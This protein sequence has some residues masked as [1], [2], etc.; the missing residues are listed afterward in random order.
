MDP[1]TIIAILGGGLLVAKGLNKPKA[2]APRQGVF[3]P[4]ALS[5]IRRPTA[6]GPGLSGPAS[7]APASAGGITSAQVGALAGGTAGAALCASAGGVGAAA[8]PLCASI[9]AKAGEVVA[10]YGERFVDDLGG[11]ISDAFDW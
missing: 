1:V 6:Y 7:Q 9:G 10:E 11:A 3:R 5:G 2:T 4:G 8:S